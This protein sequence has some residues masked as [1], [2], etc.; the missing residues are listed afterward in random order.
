MF[1]KA[2]FK[3]S[4]KANGMMWL[5]I[6]IAECFMLSCV[7]VIS[8]S[9]NISNVKDSV[10]DTI[11]QREIDA[12]LEKRSLSYYE[13]SDTSLSNFDGYYVTDFNTEYPATV[14]YK[15]TFDT[16]ALSKPVQAVGESA[17]DYLVRLTTWKDSMPSYT[18]N[19]EEV[20]AYLFNQ[21]SSAM[22]SQ[23]DYSSLSDYQTAMLAWQKK[24]PT[25]LTA[26]GEG[27]FLD[28]T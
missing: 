12:S 14:A 7:M 9:G 18:T 1:S 3:Q 16:W 2:L 26:A 5:I 19:G 8:G 11:I 21:W 6:T 23:S 27:A 4:I 13:Y 24:E 15:V 17:S 25:A 28:A 20:Y 22:P 10:E